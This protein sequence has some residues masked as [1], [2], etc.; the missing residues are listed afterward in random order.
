MNFILQVK[1]INKNKQKSRTAPLIF[2]IFYYVPVASAY[3]YMNAKP[4]HSTLWGL[5]SWAFKS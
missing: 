5:K 1:K 3:E 4:P 2:T